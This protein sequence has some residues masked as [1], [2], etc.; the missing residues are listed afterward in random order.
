LLGP[1][2]IPSKR[3]GRFAPWSSRSRSFN[4][5]LLDVDEDSPLGFSAEAALHQHA[6]PLL[7]PLDEISIR[8]LGNSHL[9]LNQGL[10]KIVMSYRVTIGDIVVFLPRIDLPPNE[11]QIW[12]NV[13]PVVAVFTMSRLG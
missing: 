1:S 4:S 7:S 8:R 13:G 3:T 2:L 9:D 6:A 12:L 11:A 5:K 10:P